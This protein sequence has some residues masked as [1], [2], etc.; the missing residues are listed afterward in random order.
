MYLDMTYIVLV[1][2]AVIL[3]L[4]ASWNVK[5][6]FKKYAKVQ[7]SRGLTGADAAL[8][9]RE[10]FGDQEWVG[11]DRGRLTEEQAIAAFCARLPERLH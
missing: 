10:V 3:S 8:L 11:L 2:P 1:L 6:T 5:R 7:N 9:L 4:W